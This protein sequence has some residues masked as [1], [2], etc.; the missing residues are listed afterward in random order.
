MTDSQI[1]DF[2]G[3]TNKVAALLNRHKSTVS[4]WRR[5]GFPDMVRLHLK[6]IRPSAFNG[7]EARGAAIK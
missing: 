3:G 4:L 1:I 6:R 7:T 2:L 5:R